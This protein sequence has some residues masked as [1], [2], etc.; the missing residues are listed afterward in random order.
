MGTK[1]IFPVIDSVL[2]GRTSGFT[3]AQIQGISSVRWQA[4]LLEQDVDWMAE[5]LRLTFAVTDEVNHQIV[6][7][8]FDMRTRGYAQRANILLR[9]VRT[10]LGALG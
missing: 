8:N 1:V 4:V 6:T 5:F 2:A 10:A 7:S 3:P 9:C